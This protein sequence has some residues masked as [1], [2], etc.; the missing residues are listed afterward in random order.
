MTCC[1]TVNELSSHPLT[2]EFYDEFGVPMVPATAS[3]EVLCMTT[4]TTVRSAEAIPSPQ[5]VMDV[6]LTEIDNTLQDPVN[7]QREQ[8][9]VIVTSTNIPGKPHVEAFDYW[10]RKVTP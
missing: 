7:N 2:L 5:A 4:K 1:L 10:V 6:E 9:R 3:Y 8:R